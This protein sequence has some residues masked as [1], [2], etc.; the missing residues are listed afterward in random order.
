[1]G[2]SI[3]IFVVL[4][5]DM[6]FNSYVFI[7]LFLIPVLMIF[8]VSIK[9]KKSSVLMVWFLIIASII[10]YGKWSF[11]QL[12]LLLI[13]ICINY[14]FAWLIDRYLTYKKMLFL[15]ALVFDIG[16][17]GYFKYSH[18]LH[19][20][21]KSIVLPLA[22]SFFTFQQIG[23][24]A[25]VY[26]RKIEIGKF[27][28]YLFFVS[29]FPQLI[30]GPIVHYNELIPQT[31]R[32]K[33][34]KFD[35]EYFTKGVVLFCV[36]LFKKVVLAD[37][38]AVLADKAFSNI[39]LNSYDAWLGLFGYSF[40]IYFDFSGYADMAIG[41]GLMFGLKL[42]INFDSP[43]KS[44][45]LIEFWR[46]WHITLSRFLKD[47]IYIPLG[48]NREG[49]FKEIYNILVTMTIGGIW[50][51]AGWN[52]LLWGVIHG[53]CLSVV[54]TKGVSLPK[55]ANTLLTFF[56]VTLLWV[57]FRADSLNSALSYYKSL[58][59]FSSFHLGSFSFNREFLIAFGF[60]IALVLPNS[61]EFSKY[62]KEKYSLN[63]WHIFV[64]AVL[65][66]ISLK[67]MATTPSLSFVYFN[68]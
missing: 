26:K 23:F 53:L 39:P 58:I 57:L 44:R 34:L 2:N 31:E 61:L 37:N 41:L 56:I 10:F 25:D 19:L 16:L 42:P 47:Y 13:S 62:Q 68:F 67:T 51:G 9:I 48:G 22:I 40:Q 49:K 12:E 59:D 32:E 46:R 64:G 50:H 8:Y 60:F 35:K 54:H 11:W 14:T 63:L 1:M 33:W 43:Y 38:F 55:Y 65:F 21:Q 18:F 27:R 29:F 66:F 4:I 5:F 30:A 6:L 20:S 24:L 36:G 45:N 17:L 52:F 7:F 15:S 3:L 28:K